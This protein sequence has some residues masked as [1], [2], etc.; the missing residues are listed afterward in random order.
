M[1]KEGRRSGLPLHIISGYATACCGRNVD[2]QEVV[3]LVEPKA[4][5]TVVLVQR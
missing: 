2:H 4:I 1:Y 5:V 3:S